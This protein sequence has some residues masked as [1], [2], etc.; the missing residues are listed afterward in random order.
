MASGAEGAHDLYASYG[1]YTVS[2]LGAQSDAQNYES[3][4]TIR[5]ETLHKSSP[6]AV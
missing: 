2:A 5:P 3:W 1:I 6:P 4:E